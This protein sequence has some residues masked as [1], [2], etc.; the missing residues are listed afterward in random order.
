LVDVQTQFQK[1]TI[2]RNKWWGKVLYLDNEVNVTERDEFVYHEMI[3]HVPMLTHNEPKSV[4]IV[5]GGD[6]AVARE[7]L[8]HSN[9][10]K[11]SMVDIDEEVIKACK[12]HMPELNN[13]A[14]DD[15][16]L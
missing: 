4:L 6:G 7:I 9:I 14:F 16:R 11:V 1:V 3:V 10:E 13:G 12:E 2:A 8:K 15:P 5:G